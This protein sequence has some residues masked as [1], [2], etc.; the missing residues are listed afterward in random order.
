MSTFAPN[1]SG[2]LVPQEHVRARESW[3]YEDWRALE[4]ASKLLKSRNVAMFLQCPDE[5]C[6]DTPLERVRSQDG[7]IT[8]RCNHLDRVV[9]RYRK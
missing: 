5:T 9:V 3:P 7:G 4:K 1:A 6:V 2:L 8:L